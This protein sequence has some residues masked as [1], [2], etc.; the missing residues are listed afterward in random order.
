MKRNLSLALM[1]LLAAPLAGFAEQQLIPAGSLL[2]CIMDEHNLSSRT[3]NVGDPVLCKIGHL[4]VYGG[5][6]LPYGSYMAGQFEA[7]KDPGHFVGKGWMELTFDHIVIPPD[8]VIPVEARVVDVPG[9]YVDRYGRIQGKGHRTRD[10]VTWMI[11]I[12][13]PIDLIN[14]PRRGP[15][16]RLKEDTR[17]T[18]KVMDDFRVPQIGPPEDESPRL[19]RRSSDYQPSSDDQSPPPPAPV[20]SAENNDEQPDYQQP[21]QPQYQPEQYQPQR[22]YQPAQQ[23]IVQVYIQPAYQPP[24]PIIRTYVQPWYVPPRVI[25]LPP[26]PT[27]YRYYGAPIA[28]VVSPYGRNYYGGY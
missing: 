5:S 19:S 6:S 16:P 21:P 4:K 23:P 11:P 2:S 28:R 24:P 1:L 7:Y 10:V 26:R 15:R 17:L 22:Q 13:W 25:Y 18:L 9:Y 3:T 27:Y 20:Q 14:L 12:L 8:T